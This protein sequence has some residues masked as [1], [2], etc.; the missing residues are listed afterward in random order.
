MMSQPVTFQFERPEDSP[1]YLLWQVTMS[2]QRK[3]KHALD[4]LDLTH[5][6]FVLLAAIAWLARHLEE[7]TQVDVATHSSTDRMMV[8]K[9]LRTLQSKGLISRQEHPTDTRAKV[10]RLTG[11]GQD[12]IQQAIRVVE[13]TDGVYFAPLGIDLPFFRSQIQLLLNR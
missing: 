11:A 12:R 5:T 7:V 1:G 3:I 9:V 6:Q 2:W 4:P 13:A 10:V 8:S